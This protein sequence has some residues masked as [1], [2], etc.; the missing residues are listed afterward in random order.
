MV[1]GVAI[2]RRDKGEKI[3]NY[4]IAYLASLASFVVKAL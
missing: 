2:V 4:Y 1:G 3:Q